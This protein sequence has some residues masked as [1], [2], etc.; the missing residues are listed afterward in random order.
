MLL[1]CPHLHTHLHGSLPWLYH[2]LGQQSFYTPE[3]KV[4]TRLPQNV[5]NCQN[6]RVVKKR[7]KHV[8]LFHFHLH[9][10]EKNRGPSLASHRPQPL[11]LYVPPQHTQHFTTITRGSPLNPVILISLSHPHASS[12]LALNNTPIFHFSSCV[13]ECHSACL[14]MSL[15]FVTFLF[16]DFLSFWRLQIGWSSAA[17]IEVAAPSFRLH[18]VLRLGWA[19]L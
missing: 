15:N 13:L 8:T 3:Y 4:W 9:G 18:L 10:K 19:A 1:H 6:P 11:G 7:K 12:A 5:I 2:D 14:V 16:Y 17:V